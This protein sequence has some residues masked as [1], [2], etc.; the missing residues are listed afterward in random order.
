MKTRSFN[1]IKEVYEKYKI[2]LDPHSA[3]GFGALKKIKHRR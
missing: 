3:I 1:I 2:I